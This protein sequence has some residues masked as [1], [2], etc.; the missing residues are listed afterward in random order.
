MTSVRVPPPDGPGDALGPFRYPEGRIRGRQ[1]PPP[2]AE[3]AL[4][5]PVPWEG[6]KGRGGGGRQC[7]SLKSLPPDSPAPVPS[8]DALP[9]G[10]AANVAM[11]RSDYHVY[12]S[13]HAPCKCPHTCVYG[14]L[15]LHSAHVHLNAYIVLTEMNI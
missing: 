8:R 10:A 15:E 13:D 2:P 14:S 1:G 4:P 5:P 12:R 3:R 6:E 11:Y 9:T 7:P